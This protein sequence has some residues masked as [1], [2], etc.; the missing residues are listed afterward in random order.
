M[1][2][3]NGDDPTTAGLTGDWLCDCARCPV[4][5]VDIDGRMF[6][7]GEHVRQLAQPVPTNC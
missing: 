1:V 7:G 2:V 3:G 4:V 5:V 6:R